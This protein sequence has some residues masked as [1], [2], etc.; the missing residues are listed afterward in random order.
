MISKIKTI[1]Q[2]IALLRTNEIT[3]RH[4]MDQNLNEM[5]YRYITQIFNNTELLING[6]VLKH[7]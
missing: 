1:N 6:L 3:A 5:K 4:F 7:N 2:C